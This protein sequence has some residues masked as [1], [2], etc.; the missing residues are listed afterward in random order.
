MPT[1]LLSNGKT[2][3]ASAEVSLLDAAKASGLVLEHSCRNGRCG[4]CKAELLSGTVMAVQP[5]L[6]LTSVERSNGWILTCASAATSDV[7][8]EIADLSLPTDVVVKTLPSRIASLTRLAPDVMKV[9]LRLPPNARFRYLPGQYIDV[10]AKDGQQRRSYSIANLRIDEGNLELHIREVPNGKMSQYW[11]DEAQPNDLL[12]FEGP[13]GTFFLREI[14][15]LDLVFLATGTGI[16]PIKAMLAQLACATDGPKPRSVHLL[17]GGR[18]LADL[19]W[20][21]ETNRLGLRYTPVLSRPEADWVGARG[22][23]QDV[24]LATP[25]A[26]DRTVVYACGSSAMIAD[27]RS[28]L[29][30]AG[31]PVKQFFADAF[32]SSS[33]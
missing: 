33:N 17:W 27:A 14:A 3:E 8:L 11:F 12:R 24:L 22:H 23:V 29:I 21:P 6:S 32:V 9:Q 26:W 25:R 16:A 7:S 31:L 2:F 30:A 15:D 4:S 10:I 19:Y 1:A 5:D 28:A 20:Q 13:R 18:H